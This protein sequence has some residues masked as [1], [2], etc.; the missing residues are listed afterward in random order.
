MRHTRK[1]GVEPG[2]QRMLETHEKARKWLSEDV[3]DTREGYELDLVVRGCWRHT[4]GIGP[5]CQR[6]LG[7]HEKAR[8]WTWLSED[9]GDPRL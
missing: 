4:I 3:R 6:M 8:S 2:C 7:T 5:G 1:L 9:V